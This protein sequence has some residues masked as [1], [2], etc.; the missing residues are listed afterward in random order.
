M[1]L[2]KATL[3]FL[4]LRVTFRN[5]KSK[6]T[7]HTT[8]KYFDKFYTSQTSGKYFIL[9]QCCLLFIYGLLYDAVNSSEIWT[10]S[11]YM[12]NKR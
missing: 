7:E 9:N 3:L 6:H 12:I 1:K 10:A 8:L 11:N 2:R 4:V 5:R